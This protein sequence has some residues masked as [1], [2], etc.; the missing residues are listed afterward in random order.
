MSNRLPFGLAPI[1]AGLAASVVGFVLAASPE[2]RADGVQV[3]YP[4][5]SGL[6]VPVPISQGGTGTTS[7]TCTVGNF[8]TCDGTTCSCSPV[9]TYSPSGQWRV[10]DYSPATLGA[11]WTGVGMQTPIVTEADN[12]CFITQTTAGAPIVRCDTTA[13]ANNATLVYNS[14]FDSFRAVNLPSMSTV[15]SLDSV[16]D[17]RF[18]FGLFASNPAG[19]AS[20]NTVRYYGIRFDTGAGDTEL[21]CCTGSGA[22]S[23]CTSTGVAPVALTAY[24]IRIQLT[25]LG[26]L[27]CTVNSTT[28]TR[29]A[30]MDAVGT[31][32]LGPVTSLTTLTTAAKIMRIG[33]F[34][35]A[36]P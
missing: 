25:A 8:L 17:V 21:Q 18:W 24:K 15:M 4:P 36:L 6:T 7:L 11:P 29:T 5:G 14:S 31:T 13:D 12:A 10:I 2:A 30:T 3:Y 34:V 28:V 35:F 33:N 23:G 9:S 20:S 16:A 27:S 19:F 22:A 26:S 1:V 32:D